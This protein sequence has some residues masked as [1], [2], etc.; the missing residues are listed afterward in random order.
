MP[1]QS[2]AEARTRADLLKRLDAIRTEVDEVTRAGLAVPGGAHFTGR[3][4]ELEE[5]AA[6]I[7][8]QLDWRKPA[9]VRHRTRAWAVVLGLV[10]LATLA[11]VILSA[12]L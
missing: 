9:L 11:A 12:V 2:G 6:S 5:E 4:L 10:S 1:D 8:E 3:R 7:K